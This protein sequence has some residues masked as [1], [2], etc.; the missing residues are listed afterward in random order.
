MAKTQ[1]HDTILQ[2]VRLM[3]YRR[4]N[5]QFLSA[6]SIRVE[7]NTGTSNETKIVFPDEVRSV[8][9]D[10]GST[11][12]YR[13]FTIS[14]TA[15]LSGS[16]LS[17]LRSGESEAA[18]RWYAIYAVKTTDNASK[19]VLVGTAAMPLQGNYSTLDSYFGV[20]GWVY[21]G[22]IRNDQ[23]SNIVPFKQCGNITYT[24]SHTGIVLAT[25]A[26]SST[27][28]WGYTAGTG[29]YQVPQNISHLKYHMYFDMGTA[30][31][32]RCGESGAAV[33]HVIFSYPAGI[34]GP[35]MQWWTTAAEGAYIDNSAGAALCQI[36]IRGWADMALGIGIN[37]QIAYGQ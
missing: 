22:L 30:A 11:F 35:N 16:H 10:L 13:G 2:L 5:L 27:L 8:T 4:P 29:Q 34:S 1:I 32:V 37:P 14:N 24:Y 18:D 20:N 21:L 25:S 9:E 7:N 17:G 12:I 15:S 33:W 3:T 19:F 36:L 6:I 31:R 26:S 23:S 28:S